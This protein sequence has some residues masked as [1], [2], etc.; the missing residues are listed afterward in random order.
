MISVKAASA[1]TAGLFL[2]AA[3]I[4][5]A[6]WQ[7]P[8]VADPAGTAA[9]LVFRSAF[10]ALALFYVPACLRAS[11]GL[12]LRETCEWCLGERAAALLHWVLIPL[13]AITW[14]SQ[15]AGTAGALLRFGFTRKH[16]NGSADAYTLLIPLI[17]LVMIAPWATRPIEQL[18]RDSLFCAK[19]AAAA[20]AGLV[21][22][23]IDSMPQTY[24]RLQISRPEESLQSTLVFWAAPPL[25]LLPGLVGPD[26]RTLASF[27]ILGIVLPSIAAVAAG[28]ST[29]AGAAQLSH[30]FLKVPDYLD[31]VCA[32]GNRVGWVKALAAAFTLL[33]ACRFGVHAL[34]RTFSPAPRLALCAV[35]GAALLAAPWLVS[36]QVLL[37]GWQY[38]AAPFV[39]LAGIFCG[40]WATR[41][42]GA[43]S[44]S[45]RHAA[46]FAWAAGTALI[47]VPP[48]A[49]G[50]MPAY[51]S[52][53]VFMGWL[54]AFAIT[55]AARVWLRRTS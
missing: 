11:L 30:G 50:V 2:N 9:G 41:S 43:F 51:F 37:W 31:F 42:H 38:A 1:F 55:G 3:L 18:A 33:T 40:A 17:L 21:L 48:A 5:F 28:L 23:T 25:L 13:W 45:E 27:T 54:A 44:R 49:E 53:P 20:V 39:T 26:R 52:P 34:A 12:G 8:L 6:G 35:S 14:A 22:S 47:V 29:M 46:I 24:A 7:Y 10:L 32:W 15:S 4:R 16:W 19:V 36:I